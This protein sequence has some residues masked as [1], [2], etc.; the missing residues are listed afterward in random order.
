MK[1]KTIGIGIGALLG[2]LMLVL[3]GIYYYVQ[4]DAFMQKVEQTAS[5]AASDSLGVPVE[6][7]SVTVVSNHEIEIQDLAIY[8]KQAECI[9]RADKARVDF[10]L[11]SAFQDPSHAVKEVTLSGAQGNLRQR[12]DGTWNV[13]DIQTK[14]ST[15][16]SFYGLVRLEDSEVTA[17]MQ[18][19]TATVSQLSGTLDFSAYPVLQFQV[20]G[21][22]FGAPVKASGS[23][24]KENQILQAETEGLD[25]AQV[26]PLLPDGL[27]PSELS[28][29]GGTIVKA[30]ISGQKMGSQLSFTGQAEYKDVAVRVKDTEVEDIHGFTSFNDTE[31]LVLADARANGQ[32]ARVHG[33]VRLDTDSPYLDLTVSSDGFDPAQ[34]LRNIPYEGAAAF[35][36]HVTGTAKNPVVDGDFKVAQGKVQDIPFQNAAAHIRYEDSRIYVQNLFATAFG[37]TIQGEMELSADDLSYTAHLQASNADVQ[38]AAAYVPQ[39]SDLQGRVSFDIGAAGVGTDGSSLQVYGS[40]SLQ[41]GAYK[42]LPIENLNASFY[43]QGQDVTIDYASLNLPNRTTLGIEGTV[44]GGERLDLAFYG[45]HVDL[46]LASK[47]EPQLDL[48]GL[49]DFEGTVH[50]NM[51]DPQVDL[52]FTATHGTL[53]K[54]PYDDLRFEAAGSLDG[55]A[56]K[57][58][59]LVKDGKQTWYVDGTVGLAGERRIDLRVDTVGARME[60]IAALAFP[61]QPITGNVDNTIHFTGTL[62]HPNAVG[63]IHFYRGSYNGVLLSGMDGDYFMKDGYTRLQDFHIFSPMVDMDLNGTVDREMNL[64]L[65]ASVH[66]IDMERFAHKFPYPVSGKGTFSGKI[67]GNLSA[68]EF[69][70]MLDA[71]SITLNG[72]E[73]KSVHGM[74]RYRDSVLS[75][76][77]FGFQQN[78]GQYAL[79]MSVDM[80]SHDAS[81]H[82]KVENG[83]INAISAVLNL[84]NDIVTGRLTSDI[85]VGGT[86]DNPSL[87]VVGTMPEGQVAGYDI[88]DVALNLHLLDSVIYIDELSGSQGTEGSFSADG[89]VTIG[90]PIAATFTARNLALGMFTKSAGLQRDVHGT[91]DIDVSFG[92]TTG[93]PSADVTIAGRNGGFEG[94]VFDSL[95]GVFHLKNGLVNVEN[96]SVKKTINQKDYEASAHGIVPLRALTSTGD[97]PSDDYE[98]IKLDVRLDQADLSLLPFVSDQVDWALGATKGGLEITGTVAHPLINGSVAVPSGAMKLKPL[99]KP[100]TDMAMELDFNGN[101]M[102]VRN[103]SGKMGEGTYDVQGTLEMAGLKPSKYNFTLDAKDLDIECEFFRGPLNASLTVSNDKFF[104]REMPKIAGA[105]NLGNCTISVPSLPEGD[106]SLPEVML[107]LDINVGDKVHAYSSYLYDMYLTGKVH[108]GGSTAHPKSSG[109]ISVK[110]GGTVSYLKT[111]FNVR[112]GAAYFNQV[113]SFLPSIVFLADT[114]LTQAKVYLALSGPLDNMTLKLTSSPEMSQTEIIRMLTLR[115]AYKN[116]DANLDAGDLLIV[117]LQMSF[118]SEVEDVMRNML[119]LDRFTIARGSGSDFDHHDE[120]SNKDLDVYHVEMGKYISDKVMLKYVQQIGGNDMHRFGVQYDMNDRLGLTLDRESDDYIVGVEARIRF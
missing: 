79:V 93:N 81:G 3:G 119:W 39:L 57:D 27:L 82:V 66:E 41:A 94:S 73:L 40:A 46:S 69:Y 84:K 78:E 36:A 12:E 107:D 89:S 99:E 58:F 96:A 90:G 37:G 64:E 72:Q 42:A 63:Y 25:I 118:L 97:D 59:S 8:D 28:I 53:F 14:S 76:D 34:V 117:G 108:F 70:G 113:D 11:F 87:T 101:S 22:S 75:V 71:P 60:D 52:K 88:H 112:E 16:G 103:F 1:R 7:G 15:S 20:N 105:V 47:L 120:E 9:A 45:G 109:T 56:I 67:R 55:V 24:R 26:L 43:A 61:D 32:S 111:A 2:V 100:I 86:Y 65:D 4:T 30:K 38:Q 33:S 50:G 104:G 77:Q 95:S 19:K 106:S 48:S 21:E 98:Q 51:T 18:G 110:R 17:S 102:T 13:E 23:Y 116:G 44:M 114:R 29:E 31:V 92:G 49:G 80:A 62:D 68:P 10:R 74:M 35:T 91:A 115:D 54:Q 83:D 5:S 6:I 85:D